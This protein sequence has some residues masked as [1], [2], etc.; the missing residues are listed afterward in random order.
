M[1]IF[2]GKIEKLLIARTENRLGDIIL[3]IPLAGIIKS[4]FPNMHIT[5]AGSGYAEAF[6][7][8][9]SAIDEF[10][11]WN[12]YKDLK[13]HN[14][15]AII[16]I[17]PWLNIAKAAWQAK[18]PIRI[19]MARKWHH[20][21]YA[22]HRIFL[23]QQPIN[24]HEIQLNTAFLAALGIDNPCDIDQLHRYYGWQKESNK[25]YSDVISDTKCNI[26]LHPK[27]RGSAPEWLLEH[28]Y[29][30]ACLLDEKKFNVILSGI[31]GEREYIRRHCPKLFALPHI[32]NIVGRYELADFI[33]IVEQADCL[34]ASSTGPAHIAA[35]AGISTIALYTPFRPQHPNR[36]RP[37]GKRVK[38]LCKG[39]PTNNPKDIDKINAITPQEVRQ[40]IDEMLK[41]AAG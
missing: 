31:N 21:L 26:I 38:V 35:A 12:I 37:I 5:F 30:L 32:T 22:N 9:T 15:D 29:R 34:V 25:S 36:W 24:L 13:K 17:S 40:L 11:H 20:W 33:N 41:S 8:K 3:T 28:Y 2:P 23:K 4:Y 10:H 19:G 18:I 6:T 39:Q 14:A 1:K 7:K 16:L 27:S